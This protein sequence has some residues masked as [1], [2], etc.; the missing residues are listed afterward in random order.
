M[1]VV[2]PEKRS[3]MMAGIKGKNTKPEMM[4]RRALFAEGFRYRLH[5]RK[6]LPGSP[7]IV[8][9]SKR[10]VIFVHG[11]FWHRHSECR[12]ARLPA[13]NADFW[14]KKLESNVERDEKA[15]HSL[16]ALGWPVLIVWECITR[17]RSMALDIGRII[18]N[19]IQG[20]DQTG[21]LPARSP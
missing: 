13:S 10:V 16:I 20:D 8:L 17:D 5:H 7:D 12:Y 2:D 3:R 19:W 4:V 9:K 11:C 15:I 6:D 18:N 21:E 1:D 14:S